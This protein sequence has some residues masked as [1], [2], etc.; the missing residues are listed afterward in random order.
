MPL[1]RSKS[2]KVGLKDLAGDDKKP[3]L[4][5]K[6]PSSYNTGLSDL[7]NDSNNSAKLAPV[8]NEPMPELAEL[9]AQFDLFL[10]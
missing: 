1:F 3:G 4:F 2:S 6:S 7:A 10:V 8:I 9:D 5:K